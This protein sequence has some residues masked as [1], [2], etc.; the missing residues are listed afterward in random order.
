MANQIVNLFDEL[1]DTLKDLV[2]E[3]PQAKAIR[4]FDEVLQ[5][6]LLEAP[7]TESSDT[8]SE[9]VDMEAFQAFKASLQRAVDRT[10]EMSALHIAAFALKE[11]KRMSDVHNPSPATETDTEAASDVDAADVQTTAAENL[12]AE[13][14]PTTAPDEQKLSTSEQEQEVARPEPNFPDTRDAAARRIADLEAQL[15]SARA[16]LVR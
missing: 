6:L 14:T 13:A 1:H 15:A 10:F 12:A 7:A 11:V 4:E 5:T 16:A 3:T 2:D 8:P 9:L